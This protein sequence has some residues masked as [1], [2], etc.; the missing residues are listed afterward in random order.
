[1][2]VDEAGVGGQ[3]LRRRRRHGDGDGRVVIAGRH[4]VEVVYE[5]DGEDVRSGGSSRS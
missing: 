5:D 1:V 3:V 4:Y 2:V